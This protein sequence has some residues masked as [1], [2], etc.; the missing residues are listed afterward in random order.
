M[1]VISMGG[2]RKIIITGRIILF[3]EMAVR[4][5]KALMAGF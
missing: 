5:I 1:G 3:I 4:T 2:A